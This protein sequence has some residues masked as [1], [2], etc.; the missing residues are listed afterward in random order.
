MAKEAPHGTIR[1]YWRGCRCQDC[2]NANNTY[3]HNKRHTKK[4]EALAFQNDTK[5]IETQKYQGLVEEALRA[6]RLD[7]T[8]IIEMTQDARTKSLSPQAQ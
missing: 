4:A 1:R 2:R 5:P 8:Y 7:P 3:Q 6:F